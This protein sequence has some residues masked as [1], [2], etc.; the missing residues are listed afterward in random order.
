MKTFFAIAMMITMTACGGQPVDESQQPSKR[1]AVPCS[2][3]KECQTRVAAHEVIKTCAESFIGNPAV[4]MST[5]DNGQTWLKG[6]CD[7]TAK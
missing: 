3:S 6:N 4:M 7:A 1:E 2:Q 5:W